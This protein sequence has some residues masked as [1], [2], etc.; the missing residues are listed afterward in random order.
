MNQYFTQIVEEAV[1]LGPQ[2][3]GVASDV[4]TLAIEAEAYRTEIRGIEADIETRKLAVTTR[5]SP[6]PEASKGWVATRKSARMPSTWPTWRIR[7][8]KP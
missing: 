3:E 8:C 1:E 4:A 6:R 5:S 7:R 2:L